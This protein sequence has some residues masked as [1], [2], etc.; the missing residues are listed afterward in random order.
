MDILDFLPK[1]P[2]I[3]QTKYSVLNPYEDGFYEA[4]F[5]KK[6]F[7]ELK[8]DRTEIFPK[9]RG[10]LTKYQKTIARYMSSHTPYD[11]LLLVHQM[12]L[13][14]CVLP[15]TE[16]Y[17]NNNLEKI[18]NLWDLYKTEETPDQHGI[19]TIPKI[20]LNTTSYD[21]YYNSV[22]EKRVLNLYKQYIKE[23]VRKISLSNGSTITA[24][25]M[26]KILTQEGWKNDILNTDEVAVLDNDKISYAQIVNIDEFLYEGWV[27]DVEVEE[28][29]NYVANGIVTHNTCSAIGA[30]EQIKEEESTF[31]GAVILDT[32]FLKIMRN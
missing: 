9:E 11:R 13:G 24:T 12:G 3:D 18:E 6:E 21:C 10:M 28:L 26:H 8:L 7:Y 22:V 5:H 30:I 27:Y 17:I 29:H 1:Y 31:D 32:I 15:G 23:I 2:N 19:W 16:I 25:K 14:K 20:S 4:I